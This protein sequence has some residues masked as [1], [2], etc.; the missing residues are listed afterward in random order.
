M[1]NTIQASVPSILSGGAGGSLILTSSTAGLKGNLA[2]GRIGGYGYGAAKHGVIGRLM[3]IFAFELAAQS[4]RVMWWHLLE[5]ALEW[6]PTN[7]SCRSSR[8]TRRSR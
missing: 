2:F 6:A 3:R 7:R 1:F 5:S 8:T 4:I